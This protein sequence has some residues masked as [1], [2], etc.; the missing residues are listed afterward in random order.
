LGR[1][2]LVLKDTQS[3]KF[4]E[5][6]TVL[7]GKDLE[8]LEGTIAR[9]AG[10]ALAY[11][12]LSMRD[13]TEWEIR[14]RLMDGGIEK[15]DVVSDIIEA[16]RH[17]GYV[18]DRR[19]ASNFILFMTAHRPSGPHLLKQKLRQVGISEDIIDTEIHA[20]LSPEREEEMALG[21]A[22][23]KLR[24]GAERQRMVR[25]IHGFLTRRGFRSCVVNDICA[26]ILRGEI[27]GENNGR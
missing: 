9:S 27:I 13:R 16:L 10:M 22:M 2:F 8:E 11:R 24:R 23:E 20:V 21:L 19:F 1:K 26:R 18:N 6:G 14:K 4:L 5:V 7:I 15:L 12:F 3:E 25:R 17:R